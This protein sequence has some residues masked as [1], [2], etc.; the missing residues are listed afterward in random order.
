MENDVWTAFANSPSRNLC[1]EVRRDFDRT[2]DKIEQ[3]YMKR[4]KE[5]DSNA[6]LIKDSNEERIN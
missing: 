3:D 5:Y 4:L 6:N 2:F 1:D